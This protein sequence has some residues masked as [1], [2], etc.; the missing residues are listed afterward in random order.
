M[1]NYPDFVK[2][3]LMNIIDE[4]AQDPEY[5][6]KNPNKDFIRNRKLNF[7]SV[8][9]ILLSIGGGSISKELLQYFNYDTDAASAS[10]FVQQRDKIL[11]ATFEVL[12]NKFTNSFDNLKTFQGYRLIAVDGSDL[13]IAHNP[14]DKD[15]Y[16][17]SSPDS[18]G[19]NI[20]HLNAMVSDGTNTVL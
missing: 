1:I 17:Q 16:A 8:I 13:N 19:F 2:N 15:T 3:T 20:L 4:M 12:L 10:A 14:N 6:V 9:K 11:P 18:R 7:K 5:Y